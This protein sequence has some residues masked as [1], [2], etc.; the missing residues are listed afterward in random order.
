MKIGLNYPFPWNAY[1][2]YFGG[3]RPP[4]SAPELD[5][6]I[7]HLGSNLVPLRDE[8]GMSVVRIFL[9]CNLANYG[10][11]TGG[12][13]ELP[14]ALHPKFL[15]HMERMLVEFDRAGVQVIPSLID[16]KALG[17]IPG[18][19]DPQNG[20]GG[21]SSLV[22]DR[23]LSAAFLDQVLEPLLDVAE[24]FRSTIYC[25]EVVNEPIWNTLPRPL[26]VWVAGGRTLSRGDLVDFLNQA[27]LRIES[28]GL[29]S[30]VGHRFLSDLKRFPAGTK[31][32]IHFYPTNL[33][34]ATFID[35]SLPNYD[36]SRAFVGEFGIRA[37]GGPHGE[38][39]LALRGIDR[40]DTR[41][42]VAARLSHIKQKG[43]PLCLLWPDGRNGRGKRAL[44]PGP[45]PIQLSELAQKGVVDFWRA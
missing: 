22:A 40:R 8:L 34:G 11:V 43:Y 30:T 28:R 12:R 39:W 26:P 41:S 16:F 37:P 14:E 19:K 4:G 29:Q 9:L 32:Q 25:F 6:W 10:R 20:C 1:G 13:C 18:P 42:R 7:E 2:L 23:A 5:R 24:S 21:R 36:Q 38:A 44:P 15:E 31:R 45:D 3:G 35:R 33:L 27:L 17:R